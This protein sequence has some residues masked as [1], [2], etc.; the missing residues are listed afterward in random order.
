VTRSSSAW[1]GLVVLYGLYRRTI[2]R[3]GGRK[4]NPTRAALWR[5]AL[6]LIALSLVG[7]TLWHALLA[8]PDVLVFFIGSAMA[9]RLVRWA[10]RRGY[11]RP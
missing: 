4:T 5:V 10:H 11:F 3:L 2:A 8:M 1:P 6:A 7:R 9:L